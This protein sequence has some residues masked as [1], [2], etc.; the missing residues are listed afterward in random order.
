MNKSGETILRLRADNAALIKSLAAL[1][2]WSK[3]NRGRKDVNPYCIPEVNHALRVLVSIVG[4]C[5]YLDVDT[6]RLSGGI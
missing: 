6:R 4:G 5:D 1:L 3:G 2:E